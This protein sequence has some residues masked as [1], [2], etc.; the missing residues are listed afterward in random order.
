MPPINLD[1]V[2]YPARDLVYAFDVGD[3]CG[4]P[5]QREALLPQLNNFREIGLYQLKVDPEV[6]CISAYAIGAQNLNQG[7]T[8][9]SMSGRSVNVDTGQVGPFEYTRL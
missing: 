2:E 9:K 5:E 8:Q 3:I 1:A 4:R 6:P 7:R